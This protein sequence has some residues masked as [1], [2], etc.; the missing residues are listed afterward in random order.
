MAIGGTKTL[1]RAGFLQSLETNARSRRSASLPRAEMVKGSPVSGSG[2]VGV[3]ESASE[4][5]A[6]PLREVKPMAEKGW[7]RE[8]WR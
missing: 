4:K 6:M 1:I 5:A 3:S 2:G 7:R 8:V